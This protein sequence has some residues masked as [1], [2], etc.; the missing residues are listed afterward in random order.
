MSVNQLVAQT[1]DFI[2]EKLL[3]GVTDLM[4][5]RHQRQESLGTGQ[6]SAATAEEGAGQDT[7]F[8][9]AGRFDYVNDGKNDVSSREPIP[10]EEAEEPRRQVKGT[11]G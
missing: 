2:K 8:A 1:A 11:A 3:R 6:L 5:Q 7:S 4:K 10:H 9:V